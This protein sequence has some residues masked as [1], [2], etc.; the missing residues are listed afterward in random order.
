ML[1]DVL[2]PVVVRR[3]DQPVDLGTPRQ[4][5]VLAALA[6]AGGRPLPTDA[7]IDRVWGDT[8]PA[9]VLGTLHG[10]VA[11]LRR[12]LEPDRAPRA[13]PQVLVTV[14]DAYALRDCEVAADAAALEAAVADARSVLAAL[15]DQLR[16]RAA[17]TDRDRVEATAGALAAALATWRGAPYAD[18]GDDPTAL[19]ER[20]RLDGVRTAAQELRAVAL[21]ALGRHAEILLELERLTAAHPLHERWWALYAVALTRSQRQADALAALTTLRNLLGDELGVDPSPPVRDLQT[22]IL[23]QD[24]SVAWDEAAAAAPS[25][26]LDHE[27]APRRVPRRESP[28]AP[29]WRLAGRREELARL[30]AELDEAAAGRPRAVLVTGEAGIGKSR[31][32]Q[33]LC[34]TAFERGFTVAVGQCSAEG[35]PPLWPFRAIGYSLHEQVGG[36]S[37]E[38][39]ELILRGPPD[40]FATLDALAAE[41]E[42]VAGAHPVVLVLEDVQWAD[43]A[44]QRLVQRVLDRVRDER[45]LLVLTL[46]RTSAGGDGGELAA[47]LARAGGLRLDLTGLPETDAQELVAEVVADAAPLA[48]DLWERSAGNPFFLIELA[49]AAGEVSGSLT[50][51]VLSRVRRLP[52]ATVA[53]LEAAAVVDLEFD[54]DLVAYVTGTAPEAAYGVLAPAV[55]AGLVLDA[56]RPTPV[57]RF[58]HG[59]VR[60]VVHDAMGAATRARS[61]R[62]VAVVVSE[63]SQLRRV[64][65]RAALVHHWASTGGLYPGEAWRGVVLAAEAARRQ[66][67]YAEEAAHLGTALELQAA[68]PG[69]D[70]R[71]R[72]EL[73]MMRADAGRWGGDWDQ[74]SVAVDEAVQVAEELGDT[75]LATRAAIS[76][77]EGAL[78]QVRPYGEVHA[79]I[80]EALERAL[81]RLGPDQQA[82]TARARLALATELYYGDDV[83]RI[84]GL[85][86]DALA[87]TEA[88]P[89]L[90][91]RA[92]AY[93]AAFTARS[94]PDALD[95]RRRYAA[96][97]VALARRLDDPRTRLVAEALAVSA[98]SE[99]G[100]ADTVRR[101]LPRVV[102]LCRDRGLGTAEAMLRVVQVPWLVMEGRDAEADA[103]MARLDE[104]SRAIGMPNIVNAAAATGMVRALLNGQYAE[105]AGFME[106]FVDAS[107]VPAGAVGTLVALR[108]GEVALARRLHAAVGVDLRT[109]S[110]M[111]LANS[112]MACEVALGLGDRPLALAAYG[113]T[114]PYAGR[115]VSAGTATPIGPVDTYLALGAAGLGD[116]DGALRHFDRGLEQ[117]RAWR[118]PALVRRLEE[119]ED[120]Y[121]R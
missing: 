79:P 121:L 62:A 82:L 76:T 9:G 31:L 65:Q 110:F 44:S 14:G 64:D 1:V 51:V 11:A 59:V 109:R 78:W 25:A 55:E 56:G 34:A 42:R 68:D 63:R 66:G 21:L 81:D 84:D 35:A 113:A 2:G 73:L 71:E 90:R 112:A 54:L 26:E 114:L 58:A 52:A 13:E 93:L 6:L 92:T 86:A 45:L 77:M 106:A 10:Y 119:L 36:V 89:D 98:A 41:A 87:H 80:V 46:R 38:V 33:E 115:M 16:P 29:R 104:L 23:R 70:L 111:A 7:L 74:V 67:A 5:A 43:P 48:A 88:S 95:D 20:V 107:R 49:R 12:A 4:R 47:A 117:A 39:E 28:P 69:S 8:A 27:P 30:E 116:R 53:L 18:L 17:P 3:D 120:R 102:A 15:P 105:L 108:A 24:P 103:P 37:D 19:A 61:H 101:E 72:F 100:D 32:V 99:A 60:E 75:E 85:V 50:D 97:A 118:L 91:L 96:E 94:R 40:D 83:E 22:A 57:Y